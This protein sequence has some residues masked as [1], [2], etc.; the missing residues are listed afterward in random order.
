MK[1]RRSSLI[2]IGICLLL[3]VVVVAAEFQLNWFEQ[4]VGGYLESH[5]DERP[6]LAKFVEQE[7]RNSEAIEEVQSLLIL[8]AAQTE[9]AEPEEN[10]AAK[11]TDVVRLDGGQK[12][13]MTRERMLAVQKKLDQFGKGM[14]QILLAPKM[15]WGKEWTRSI[16]VRADWLKTGQVFFTDDDNYILSKAPLSTEQFDLFDAYA[17]SSDESPFEKNKLRIYTPQRF[18]AMLRGLPSTIRDQIIPPVRFLDLEATARRIGISAMKSGDQA[19][20]VIE[21]V[22]NQQAEITLIPISNLLHREIRIGL[23]EA[24]FQTGGLLPDPL[25]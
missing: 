10:D 6:R 4:F 3:P 2:I 12:I 21:T 1:L 22:I 9:E 20:V 17:L 5:N 15:A 24:G 8:K 25:D 19:R 16:F 13:V 23:G 18:F 7:A 14:P 11:S